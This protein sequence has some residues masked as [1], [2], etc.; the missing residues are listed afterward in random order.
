MSYGVSQRTPFGSDGQRA[1]DLGVELLFNGVAGRNSPFSM[2]CSRIF[3]LSTEETAYMGDD[4]ERRRLSRAALS[5]SLRD[6]VPEAKAAGEFRDVR[7]W[8]EGAVREAAETYHFAESACEG[9][10]SEPKR[11]RD[12]K[13]GRVGILDRFILKSF[14]A[15]SFS[16]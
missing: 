9:L 4:C 13:K 10:H 15:P 2:R 5:R 12:E 11:D 6:A 3:S 1:A 16:A 7:S 14:P 8:R